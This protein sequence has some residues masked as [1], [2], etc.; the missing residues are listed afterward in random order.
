MPTYNC[1]EYI[2][3]SIESVISQ[4]VSD[5]EIQIVD[6]CSTDNT[7]QALQ[8][9]LMKYPTIHYYRLPENGGPA[10]A[11]TEAIKRATGRYIAFLDSDDL[12]HPEKLEKQIAFMEKM[13]ASFSC[14]AYGQMDTDGKNLHTVMIP[15][16]KTDYKKC[17]RLS[18]PIGNLTVMYNQEVL[19][20]FE[21]PS[22]K[23]RNDFALWLQI[24]KKTDFC[25]GMEEVLGTY[26]LG[27]EGSVSHNKLAQAKYHWQLYHG[28]EKHNVL[29]SAYEV[30]CWAFVK[31]TGIGIDKRKV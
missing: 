5:W 26:R 21:V 20:K 16:S 31:G 14:T 17:I 25:Y 6:D 19:G 29:C 7:E 27:R 28:I 12:W 3:Q 13:G 22:I 1:G 4:T 10:V 8:P 23:K 30:V 9:Y 24:L 18:N 11:R 2:V 15:P